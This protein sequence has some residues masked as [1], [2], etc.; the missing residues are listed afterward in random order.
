[1]YLPRPLL[2]HLYTTL[3]NTL[4]PSSSPLLLL[5]APTVDAICALRILT[6]QI[7][8]DFIPHKVRPVGGYAELQKAGEEEVKGMM[9]TAGGEGGVVVCLGCGGGVNVG[10]MLGL[11]SEGEDDDGGGVEGQNAGH[12]VEVWVI[13]AHRGW[14]LENVFGGNVAA[15]RG[16]EQGKLLSTYRP[17]GAGGVIVWDEGDIETDLQ[18]ER[19][20]YFALQGM[21]EITEEDL[22]AAEDDEEDA[23][24]GA[25][26]GAAEIG[27]SSQTR[28]RKASSQD[29]DADSD[30][31][32]AEER[33]ARRRRSNSSLPI[34]STP[35][36]A[37]PPPSS[38]P[39]SPSAI[40]PSSPP[41]RRVTTQKQL[42]R[43]LLKL[44]RRHEAT[45]EAYYDRGS[46]TGEPVSSILY[47]LVSELGREDNEVLWLAVVG[48]E[49]V[50]LSHFTTVERARRSN[51]MT[52]LE[53]LKAVLRDEVRRLNPPATA[54]R[55]AGVAS[56]DVPVSARS[57]TDTSIRLSPEPRF[58]LIRH[59]SLLDSMLHTPYLATRL[60][61]WN[62][63][64]RK[65]L[66]KLLAKMGISLQEAGKGYLHLDLEVKRTLGRRV[67]KFAEQ[68]GL[69]GLVPEESGGEGGRG[70]G[71]V[72][73]WGWRG[74][75]SAGDVVAIVSAI[76]EVGPVANALTGD[77]GRHD[78]SQNER[79]YNNRATALPSPPHSS[80]SGQNP[81]DPA[82]T[83]SSEN[84][85]T[86]RFF[87]AY[88]ALSPTSTTTSHLHNPQ[89]THT[90]QG[91]PALFTHLPLAQHLSRA[92]L[93]TGS[94]LISKN[95]IR[96]LRS[97]RL[98]IVKE[99]PDL[100]VFV[101]PGALVKLG[102][103]VGEAVGVLKGEKRGAGGK[104][105]GKGGEGEG[106][107]ALVLGCLDEGRG[108]YVV[109]GLGSG[110][111][112]GGGGVD[113]GKVRT[114]A[115]IKEREERRKR[116]I[117]ARLARKAEGAREKE[118]Q[119]LAKRERD[120]AN[121][122]LD[123]DDEE[124]AGSDAT[125]SDASSS[126]GSSGSSSDS[127]SDERADVSKG[128][129]KGGAQRSLF[130]LAFQAVVAETGARVRIDSFEH[131]VVEVRKEDLAGFLE[132]LS[133]RSLVD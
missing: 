69:E 131:S 4:T 68:Y 94:A 43:Q 86:H 109:V 88:D 93:R 83:N 118:Q 41:A 106:D 116:K 28:K 110:G 38:Q 63:P 122:L 133:L 75:L 121:G 80:D 107:G 56:N 103:W 3:L 104:G 59:W 18:A 21:P 40:V 11:T 16:V 100:G 126:S 76:L 85:T 87:A 45:L 30:I 20:A 132:G 54:R 77:L 99:G 6:A 71:F 62:E 124:E 14:N 105:S 91:L 128:K 23:E 26:E 35:T 66:N 79:S 55:R 61:I 67:G 78:T 1:M 48:V 47:S 60:H 25:E 130:A 82:P 90:Q 115:E 32:S 101:D 49:S 15:R 89:H 9:K 19:E 96:H 33:P 73:S 114:K 125:E 97:F 34:P 2:S 31:D 119:K 65:R 42:R 98:G 113:G 120:A 36:S 27:N 111:A 70:W 5:T 29:S 84:L 46:W 17:G 22:V 24:E 7:K 44:R 10:E 37:Q 129:R 51:S 74:T 108:V 112:R 53:L 117:A 123:S 57:A 81:D 39:D 58:A 95:Q 8:R 64:G 52:K 12:G 127:S 72:R 50:Q 13:D 102:G 92:I